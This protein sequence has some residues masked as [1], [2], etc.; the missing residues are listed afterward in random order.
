M[1]GVTCFV[2]VIRRWRARGCLGGG[3]GEGGISGDWEGTGVKE[4]DSGEGGGGIWWG[5]KED[6]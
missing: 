4:G 3:G 2:D 5:V 6:E 1:R